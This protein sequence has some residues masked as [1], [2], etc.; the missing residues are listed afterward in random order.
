MP[1]KIIL[2]LLLILICA[3]GWSQQSAYSTANLYQGI[4]TPQAATLGTFGDI[5]VSLYTGTVNISVPIYKATV[6]DVTLDVRLDYDG[7]GL[8]MSQL[9]GPTGEGWHLNCG[10]VITRKINGHPDE[11]IPNSL[12]TQAFGLKQPYFRCYSR[13]PELVNSPTG[14]YKMLR[15]TVYSRKYDFDPDVFYFNFMGFTGHFFLGNDGEWHVDSDSNVDVLLDTSD[16]N[17]STY[18]DRPLFDHFP[19]SSDSLYMQPKV[20]DRIKLR[21]ENGN[22]Y[23]FGGKQDNA[24]EYSIGLFNMCSLQLLYSWN[25]TAWYL[26]KV[27][28]RLGN[29]LYEFEYERGYYIAQPYKDMMWTVNSEYYGNSV[30][31]Y[32]NET[33]SGNF[34]YPYGGT[35]SSP[36]YLKQVKCANG[37]K[38]L[39]S[40]ADSPIGPQQ[41]WG[42]D[43]TD[44]QIDMH[45]HAYGYESNPR[46]QK[47]PFY[48]LQVDDCSDT[49]YQY[50][51][52]GYAEWQVRVNTPLISTRAKDLTS[53]KVSTV[54]D[55]ISQ[56]YNL[57]Y[58]Y[59]PRMHLTEVSVTGSGYISV[60]T[61]TPLSYKF[62][63]DNYSS[64]P[65]NHLT[66]S[67]DHWGY[68]VGHAVSLPSP[69]ITTSVAN[70]Y[71]ISRNPDPIAMK[72][73]SLTQIIYPTGGMSVLEYEPHDFSICSKP[74]RVTLHDTTGIA[75]GLRI[76]S[77]TLY[78]D[79]LSQIML[80]RRTFSYKKQADATKSSGQLYSRPIYWWDSWIADTGGGSNA[81]SSMF[82]TASILP[83]ANST[84]THIGYTEIQETF[85]DGSEN[86]YTYT[87]LQD[88]NDKRFLVCFTDDAS[89]YDTY[90]ERQY[91]RGRLTK[92]EQYD[93]T[94]NLVRREQSTW[95]DSIET[96]YT[97]ASNMFAHF[98]SGSETC[99]VAGGV[100]QMFSPKRGVTQTT[101]TEYLNGSNITRNTAN[102]YAV[103]NLDMTH[104]YAHRTEVMVPI[105]RTENTVYENEAVAWEYPFTE[106]QELPDRVK[107]EFCLHP[108]KT[109]YY[110]NGTKVKE[111]SVIYSNVQTNGTYHQ[112]PCNVMERTGSTPLFTRTTFSEYTA[113]GR[114][115]FVKEYGRPD[116][117][118]L[119]DFKDNYLIAKC[120]GEGSVTWPA[121]VGPDNFFNAALHGHLRTF[122]NCNLTHLITTYTYNPFGGLTSVTTPD[123]VTTFYKYDTLMR[124]KYT[125]D[126][127]NNIISTY[128]YDYRL[129]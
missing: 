33:L 80:S 86:R 66:D 17:N 104:P 25:S 16:L 118:L 4:P 57:N 112:L 8:R 96:V 79:T 45:N 36:V 83:L 54:Y 3:K 2:T 12:Y 38:L 93:S 64:V 107:K 82:H 73:G 72:Y 26:T 18:Y 61:S 75:G 123:S 59:S 44:L 129:H 34:N 32:H 56:T 52:M 1:K 23:E 28:D 65:N 68:L 46:Y 84:G 124:L 7:S 50:R 21:D 125:Y 78:D 85:L 113:T 9:P 5:P 27:T 128:D 51:G 102:Q 109:S 77:I 101:T 30:L 111:D 106:S 90:G 89:P 67:V 95:P 71:S 29:V 122:R 121:S 31:G 117:H 63:Y 19:G 11:F 105:R 76:K 10:G 53:I 62:R 37:C 13:L 88:N 127:N 97:L 48:Y 42:K 35:V 126:S 40:M 6:R 70:E 20:I 103:R 24:I 119:W 110:T 58:D 55:N 22:M 98:G 15:D 69:P 41:L 108:H 92:L 87:G 116:L 39:F 100:Y 47:T 74:D 43:N 14:N 114:P 60:P 115:R 91:R 94:G 99:Y 120:E 49:L 81:S